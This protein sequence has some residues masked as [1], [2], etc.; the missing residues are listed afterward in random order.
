MRD[1]QYR[2]G[3]TL[4]PVDRFDFYPDPSG[5]RIHEDMMGA[6][7]RFRC[8]AYAAKD[9]AARGI[10]NA[11]GVAIAAAG[12]S[13]EERR[14]RRPSGSRERFDFY[15][16]RGPGKNMPKRAANIVGF[17]YC[18]EVPWK[19]RDGA[20]NRL[21]T[22]LG[23]EWVRG[24][25]NPYIDGEIP[26]EALIM[27]PVSGRF[28]GLGPAE[29]IRFLQDSADNLLMVF[30]D[31][32]DAAVGGPLLIG[33]AAGAIDK[34]R[35]RRR[36]FNDTIECANP[37]A[38]KPLPFDYN[39]MTLAGAELLRRKIGMR[40]ASGATNPLQSIPSG[41]RATAT[42]VSELVRLASAKVE[43]QVEN[44]ET[45]P[46]PWIGR[47]AHSRLRQFAPERFLASLAGEQF[48]VSLQDIDLDADVRF[49]GSR[50]ASNRSQRFNQNARALEL[51]GANPQMVMMFPELVTR[52]LRDGTGMEDAEQVVARAQKVWAILQMQQAVAAQ[53][54]A[55]GG[56]GSAPADRSRNRVTSAGSQVSREGGMV[57]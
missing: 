52:L 37:D 9:F 1:R 25:I 45:G 32:A 10:Y 40:E 5:T 8:P 3:F 4:R 43:Q 16:A 21:I 12:E 23:G 41:D 42:E 54:D 7:K 6:A 38:I 46:L 18:G 57:Q 48:A 51:V 34:A 50:H 26:W 53:K 22:I 29:V 20:R 17:E 13:G 19:P 15:G 27:N 56:R 47:M 30:N 24:G 2:F 39:A 28:D 36:Q 49:I 11:E 35:L 44:L 14:G 31:S 33:A 55:A